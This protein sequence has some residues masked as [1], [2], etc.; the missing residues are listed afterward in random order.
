M[1][2]LGGI[3]LG[4]VLF[5][6]PLSVLAQEATS[7]TQY[8]PEQKQQLIATLKQLVQVLLAQIQ[9]IIAAQQTLQL[10]QQTLYE[11]QQRLIAPNPVVATT[12]IP[13]TN[14]TT[15]PAAPPQYPIPQ[16]INYQNYDLT[17]ASTSKDYLVPQTLVLG[18][19]TIAYSTQW[20]IRQFPI[21]TNWK[22]EQGNPIWINPGYCND[23][24]GGTNVICPGALGSNQN[25]DPY[26]FTVALN[27]LPSPG[28]YIITVPNLTITDLSSS[29]DFQV[30]GTPM[31]F[32]LHVN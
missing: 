1:K 6:S 28:N 23:L 12:P 4:V 2:K 7:T 19:F 30:K 18:K 26:E 21:T 10:Q 22:V 9:Q 31:N 25:S 27:Y 5:A 17:V 8:T 13:I 32:T 20:M 29:T 24:H 15:T 3:V 16:I 11:Q 14:S